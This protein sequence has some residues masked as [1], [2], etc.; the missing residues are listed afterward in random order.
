MLGFAAAVC[1]APALRAFCGVFLSWVFFGLMF[2]VCGFN[3]DQF[4]GFDPSGFVFDVQ[5]NTV[6]AQ[7][8]A[9]E[10]MKE[11]ISAV[12]AIVP[13]RS[14]NEIV[15]VLQHFDN[16]V[17]RT[18]QAFMEGERGSSVPRSRARLSH[19]SGFCAERERVTDE[20]VPESR[21]V[22][23]QLG[24]DLDVTCELG[25]RSGCRNHEQDRAKERIC[26]WLFPS[27]PRCCLRGVPKAKAK[28]ITLLHR[29]REL[30]RRCF[31]FQVWRCCHLTRKELGRVPCP[32]LIAA[33]L[34][35]INSP[36]KHLIQ[37][38]SLSQQQEEEKQSEGA[39]AELR[40]RR[41]QVG[42]RGGG[43]AGAPRAGR[44]QR[45]PRQPHDA[46]SADSLSEGLDALSIDAREL[47]DCDVPERAGS[48]IEKSVKDLQRCSVSLARYRAVLKEEMDASIKKMKQVFAELQSSL[49]W[50]G[51]VL[52]GD[53]RCQ[54]HSLPRLI[55]SVTERLFSV[56]QTRL[57][58][59]CDGKRRSLGVTGCVSAAPRPLG[60][61]V[62]GASRRS[63]RR[64]K[65]AAA[66]RGSVSFG[67]RR[68][69][70]PTSDAVT[71]T[72]ACRVSFWCFP[73]R[74]L[75]QRFNERGGAGTACC[76]KQGKNSRKM[77]RKS[78]KND[79]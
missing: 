13:N 50:F 57:S 10:N 52:W 27:P 76:R 9:F 63:R 3:L 1:S 41:H 11:K 20:P 25:T 58:S 40:V 15:L 38:L 28:P 62:S 70:R 68:A 5:S 66:G 39:S 7:G 33:F 14:N 36:K 2:L 44:D 77:S 51:R 32:L 73:T 29:H 45:L 54:V 8:G 12:R 64:D 37:L 59:S 69:P 67:K 53:V 71:C 46:E 79:L 4:L 26:D 35:R 55:E 19:G 6:M 48:S 21:S 18:V 47:E 16:C 61:L 23:A 78:A 22:F 60:C 34:F 30:K 56:I 65:S 43:A 31:G 42:A 49:C 17:D 75:V 72:F 24:R 74:F